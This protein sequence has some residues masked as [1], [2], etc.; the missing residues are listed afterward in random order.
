MDRRQHEAVVRATTA[1][2]QEKLGKAR[3]Q[4]GGPT[5]IQL[6]EVRRLM[7]RAVEHQTAIMEM[8]RAL[9]LA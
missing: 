2:A 7:D 9:K 8:D 1:Q 5:L 6:A 4:D 3:R